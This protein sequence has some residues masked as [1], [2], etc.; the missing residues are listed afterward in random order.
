MKKSTFSPVPSMADFILVHA[1]TLFNSAIYRFMNDLRKLFFPSGTEE[2]NSNLV[3]LLMVVYILGRVHGI[4]EER[5]HRTC[6]LDRI[7]GR[8]YYVTR[9]DFFA[10]LFVDPLRVAVVAPPCMSY[11]QAAMKAAQLE[12]QQHQT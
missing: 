10:A 2:Q 11:Q 12:A 9:M 3:I 4:R 8:G 7:D 5:N 1:Y 6:H